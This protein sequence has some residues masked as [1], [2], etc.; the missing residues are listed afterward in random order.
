MA[1][2]DEQLEED[3]SIVSKMIYGNWQQQ[4]TY[5]F[6]EL[7]IAD[8]LSKSQKT[9]GELAQS[10]KVVESYFIRFLRCAKELGYV[11]YLGQTSQYKLTPRGALLGSFHPHSKRSEARLNGADY[12]YLPWVNLIHILK[13]GIKEEYS[14]T[15]KDGTLNYLQDKPELLEVFHQAMTET[16]TTENADLIRDFDFSPFSKVLDIGSGEGTFLKSILDMNKHLEGVMFDIPGTFN[17]DIPDSNPRISKITGDFF[18]NVPDCAD[19]YTMKN[20]IHNWREFKV[21]ALFQQIYIAMTSCHGIDIP[22]ENKR[23]LIIENVIDD[24]GHNRL[25]S[26]MDLNFMILIDGAE[27]TQEQYKQLGEVCGF[28][29]EKVHA[30]GTERSILEYSIIHH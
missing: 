18:V 8:Y 21:K 22:I 10:L 23:L 19:V 13:N 11:E 24:E 12:R 16:S 1:F 14:P 20:V 30:T 26:W 25:A 6:A 29:L 2:Q 7:G 5:V 3:I 9:A 27:R 17:L 28:K 15:I 4:V